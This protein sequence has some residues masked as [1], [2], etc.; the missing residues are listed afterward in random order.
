MRGLSWLKTAGTGALMGCMLAFPLQTA[1]SALAALTLFVTSVL[2]GLLPFSIAALLITAGKT[3]P[4]PLL[5]ALGLLGGSPTGARLMQDA[6]LS[7]AQARRA[8]AATGVMSPMFFLF[9]LSGWLDSPAQGRLLLAVHWAAALLSAFLIRAPRENARVR[10]PALSVPQAI[11]QGAQ[12]MLT[13]G[14]CLAMG[15]VGAEL[16]AC[17][18]PAL[19]GLPLALLQSALEVTGGCRALTACGLPQR[20]LLPLLSFFAAFGGAGILMQNAA[21]WQRHGFSLPRLALIALP[22]AALAFLLCALAMALSRGGLS[23]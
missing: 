15:A 16:L 11:F 8:A 23:P 3:L 18:L 12:A 4:L 21:F 17:V 5:T 7:P 19:H 20:L 2:P 13:V 14:G 6:A 9:T 22:R 10:L 1:R